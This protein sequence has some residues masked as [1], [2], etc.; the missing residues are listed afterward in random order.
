MKELL[1]LIGSYEYALQL[2]H[3]TLK[4]A[5]VLQVSQATIVGGVPFCSHSYL[6]KVP[7]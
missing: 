2:T 7:Q 1:V 6:L 3:V 5:G 4:S